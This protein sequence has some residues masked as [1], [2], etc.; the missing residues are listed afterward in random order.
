MCLYLGAISVAC[1]RLNLRAFAVIL[2]A[3]KALAAILHN[4]SAL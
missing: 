4:K 1:G 3:I 2:F